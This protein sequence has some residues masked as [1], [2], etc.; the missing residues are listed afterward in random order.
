MQAIIIITIRRHTNKTKHEG[1]SSV[2]EALFS[3]ISLKVIKT[4]TKTSF[5]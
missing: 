1:I 5:W 3:K 2:D 4:N